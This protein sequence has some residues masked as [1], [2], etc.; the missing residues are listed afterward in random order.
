MALTLSMTCGLY[1]RTM[2]LIDG[3]VKPDRIDLQITVNSDDRSRQAA[4]REGN[5]MSQ[6]SLPALI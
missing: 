4:A 6:N 3:T 2:P 1:D 5:L